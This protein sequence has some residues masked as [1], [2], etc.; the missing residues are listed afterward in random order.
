[1]K[2]DKISRLLRHYLSAKEEGKEPY[3]DA[4]E[5]EDLLESFEESEDY[6]YYD[7]VLA[8]GL[9]LHP[10]STVLRIEKCRQLIYEEKYK[11]ALSSLKNIAEK[12]DQDLDMLTLECY[13]GLGQYPK[14]IK[15]LDE[16]IEE[17]VE[18]LEEVFEYIIPILNDLEATQEARYFVDRGLALFPNNLIL[19]NEFCLILEAEGNI[20]EAIKLCDELI[21]SNP[22]S[23]DYWYTLGRLYSTNEEYEKAIEA[24]DFAQTCEGTTPELRMLKAYCLYMNGSYEKA[25]EEYD[26]LIKQNADKEITTQ[27]FP[28]MAECCIKMEDYERA[29]R[30]LSEVINQP[31]QV[32][33]PNNFI[34][35]ILCCHETGREREA[36]N[37]LF[38]AVLLYPDNIRILSLAALTLAENGHKEESIALLDKIFKIMDKNIVDKET[39]TECDKLIHTGLYMHSKGEVDKAISS[40]QK[41]LKIN[42]RTPMIHIHLAMAYLDNS[43]LENCMKHLNQISGKDLMHYIHKLGNDAF[44]KNKTELNEPIPPKNLAQEFL[45]NKDNNN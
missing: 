11:E 15:L 14:A 18:Y 16:L 40:F 1:M 9:K 13:C 31:K 32:N 42:P 33:A 23:Y 19:K 37:M 30:L 34:N 45:K 12:N 2:K 35:Y 7:E 5:I 43:D 29:Y 17:D 25:L 41:V 39:K 22:F 20:S 27:C 21:D 36:S 26:E 28:L 24:F 6:T 38:K 10:D 3:F 8:L 44:K 4:D